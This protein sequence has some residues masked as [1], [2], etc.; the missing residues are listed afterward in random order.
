MPHDNPSMAT[1]A[2]WNYIKTFVC[3]QRFLNKTILLHNSKRNDLY[4]MLQTIKGER[5][6]VW[7]TI[8]NYDYITGM[9]FAH[10]L[11][12]RIEYIQDIKLQYVNIS[13]VWL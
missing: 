4:G 13:N 5:I 3:K 2:P 11:Y 6:W 7:W 1:N 9:K 10:R 12:H 8:E